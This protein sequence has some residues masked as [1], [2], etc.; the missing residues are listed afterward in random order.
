[1]S[2]RE[3]PAPDVSDVAANMRWLRDREQLRMLYQRYA[4][5]VDTAISK[6]CAPYSIPIAR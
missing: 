2:L 4:Y 3:S 6:W 5:G 1:M